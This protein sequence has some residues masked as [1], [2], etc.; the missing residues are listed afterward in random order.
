MIRK[1]QLALF[2]VLIQGCDVSFNENFEKKKICES[3]A[4]LPRSPFEVFDIGPRM[5]EMGRPAKWKSQ[6]MYLGNTCYV[7][8]IGPSV[9]QDEKDSVP[10]YYT[11]DVE[12][13]L[14]EKRADGSISE[15]WLVI[16]QRDFAISD[17]PQGFLDKKISEVVS[18][19]EQSNA[20]IFSIGTRKYEYILP[21]TMP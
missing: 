4:P 7:A 16:Y 5:H 19:Q 1:I 10:D 15:S 14:V 8:S 18:Y 12:L 3:K 9:Y 17:M 20:V 13:R 11:I 6:R 2:I 21:K